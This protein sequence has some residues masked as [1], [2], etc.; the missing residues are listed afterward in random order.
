MGSEHVQS[1]IYGLC[2]PYSLPIASLQANLANDLR[3]TIPSDDMAQGS[4]YAFVLIVDTQ[5][6]GS[7]EAEVH[8][9]KSS[10]ELLISKVCTG[11]PRDA[12]FVAVVKSYSLQPGLAASLSSA[13]AVRYRKRATNVDTFRPGGVKVAA[14]LDVLSFPWLSIGKERCFCPSKAPK[15]PAVRPFSLFCAPHTAGP[16]VGGDSAHEGQSSYPSDRNRPL[17]LLNADCE[18]STRLVL[19]EP[20]RSQR[21]PGRRTGYGGGWQRPAGSRHPS[22]HARLR[23][24]LLHLSVSISSERRKRDR[25][26]RY[27]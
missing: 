22:V 18:R 2:L 9:Y 13:V 23:R 16:G 24:E 5:L 10:R 25:S 6:G 20:P 21:V 27:R 8:A 12:V 17:F 15:M 7:G 14:L 3:V 19:M 26:Q 1:H 11:R 4:S